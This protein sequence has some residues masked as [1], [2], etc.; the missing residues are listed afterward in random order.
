MTI[1]RHCPK[2]LNQT[3]FFNSRPGQKLASYLKDLSMHS[4]VSGNTEIGYRRKVGER[5]SGMRG[6]G[7]MSL[8]TGVTIVKL[9][10]TAQNI[11]D[12]GQK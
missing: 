9:I 12:Y 5:G 6:K 4:E 8:I 3:E 2:T 10:I 11:L 7:T 1:Q